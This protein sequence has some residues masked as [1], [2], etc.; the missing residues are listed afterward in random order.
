MGDS[1]GSTIITFGEKSTGLNLL[2][3]RDK[4]STF[5]QLLYLTFAKLQLVENSGFTRSVEANHE[6]THFL[7]P[8]LRSSSS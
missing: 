6:N 7:L 1:R 4:E 8:K 2:N 5:S 3:L